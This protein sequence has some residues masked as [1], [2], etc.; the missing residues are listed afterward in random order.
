MSV[1]HFRNT[2][3]QLPV[4]LDNHMSHGVRYPFHALRLFLFNQS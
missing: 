2:S 4:H 1:A 3:T